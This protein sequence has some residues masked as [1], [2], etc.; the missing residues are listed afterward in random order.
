MKWKT[1]KVEGLGREL[2]TR[3]ELFLDHEIFF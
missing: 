1:L 2:Q 3:E